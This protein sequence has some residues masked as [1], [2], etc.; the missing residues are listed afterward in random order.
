MRRAYSFSLLLLIALILSG[1]TS[2]YISNPFAKVYSS[3][4]PQAGTLELHFVD[5]SSNP[6]LLHLNVVVGDV[7]LL[8]NNSWKLVLKQEKTFDFVSLGNQSAPLGSVKLD[9]GLYPKVRFKIK[10]ATA[11]FAVPPKECVRLN[12]QNAPAACTPKPQSFKVKVP[13]TKVEVV[14]DFVIVP[15]QTAK[16]FIDLDLSSLRFSDGQYALSPVLKVLKPEQFALRFYNKY[17]G[18][19][20]CQTV[21][22]PGE[23][24]P[25]VEDAKTCPVDCANAS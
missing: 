14:H 25:P 3:N 17:C 23:D 6:G 24:C 21:S 2:R 4:S 1:C 20:Y 11:I 9:A 22:C 18:D 16:W 19:G 15:Q 5:A 8:V 13:T 12:P 10:S 7:E